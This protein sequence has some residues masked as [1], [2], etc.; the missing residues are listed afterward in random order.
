MCGAAVPGEII[1]GYI[2]PSLLPHFLLSQRTPSTFFPKL[3]IATRYGFSAWSWWK[4]RVLQ[5][6]TMCACLFSATIYP[7]GTTDFDIEGSPSGARLSPKKVLRHGI[8]L[9][10]SVCDKK[11]RPGYCD[12]WRSLEM[13]LNLPYQKSMNIARCLEGDE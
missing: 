9:A 4:P 6:E 13:F 12:G 3:D 7:N 5:R 1:S 8:G 10:S 11:Y 2:K